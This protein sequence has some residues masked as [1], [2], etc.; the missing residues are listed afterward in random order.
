MLALAALVCS[1]RQREPGL[2][3]CRPLREACRRRDREAW[4]QVHLEDSEVL[5]T[6]INDHPSA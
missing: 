2:G 3:Q 1:V 5:S 6:L 4:A